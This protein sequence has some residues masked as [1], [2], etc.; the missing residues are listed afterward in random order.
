M[1][2]KNLLCF[3]LLLSSTA[4]FAAGCAA[5]TDEGDD[6]TEADI[7]SKIAEG[8]YKLYAQAGTVP[9]AGCD[10]HT[11]L[12]LKA[13]YY[14]TA[15]LEETVGGMCQIAVLPNT[16]AYRLKLQSTSCGTRVYTGSHTV[17][18]KRT[19]IV[20]TDNRKRTC[21]D[22]VKAQLV[23]QET[24]DGKTTTK[25][26]Y[27]AP[28]P[29][30]KTEVTGKLV[31]T[32]GIGGENTGASIAT[33]SGM[34]ELVLDQG[35]WNEFVAG[36]T[37]RVRGTTTTLSGVETHDRPAI[38]VDSLLVCPDKGTIDCMPG[39]NVRLSSICSGDD[40]AWVTANCP[41]VSFTF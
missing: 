29:S 1:T 11:Q 35:E 9:S 4:V 34:T 36:K 32:V 26:S 30:A 20:I 5:Q 31:H 17:D 2:M 18:G 14:S 39:P 6:T 21:L 33:S 8:T 13:A 12:D 40:S 27:D 24:A 19:E 3:A 38:K 25:Y 28:A 15:T 16:R 22:V 37:A 41:G 23:V 10:V 7:T